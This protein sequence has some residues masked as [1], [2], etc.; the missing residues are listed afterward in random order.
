MSDLPELKADE[1][2]LNNKESIAILADDIA[3]L[4][5]RGY[6]FQQIVDFLRE[7]DFEI[8]ASTLKTYLRE[9]KLD[10]EKLPK[11]N[12]K[13]IKKSITQNQ[14]DL[15]CTL[16][17]AEKKQATKIVKDQAEFLIAPDRD[18]L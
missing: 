4:R 12:T 16:Q 11:K 14:K 2:Q 1:I 9:P 15:G 8:T 7:N 5:K 13:K 6:E 3:I 18:V 17:N 10:R